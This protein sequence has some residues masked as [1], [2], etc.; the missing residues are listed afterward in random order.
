MHVEHLGADTIVYLSSEKAGLITVRLFGEHL[1][2]PDEIVYASPEAGH[3]HK[4]DADGR[5]IAAT[6]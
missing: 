3:I 2:E 4:F 5:A 1:Y 6:A